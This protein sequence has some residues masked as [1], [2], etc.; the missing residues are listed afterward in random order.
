[1]EAKL[2][3]KGDH[4]WKEGDEIDELFIIFDGEVELYTT[5]DDGTDFVIERLTKGSILN[6]NTFLV[7]QKKA[8]SVRTSCNTTYYRMLADTFKDVASEY[9]ILRN[10]YNNLYETTE[11]NSLKMFR[12]LDY[13]PGKSQFAEKSQ[14]TEDESKRADLALKNFKNAVML[15][16]QM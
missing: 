9:S 13:F 4:L 10:I 1:M 14:L 2:V 6:A 8:S 11:V 12:N 5:L 3:E 16:L 7:L 15:K